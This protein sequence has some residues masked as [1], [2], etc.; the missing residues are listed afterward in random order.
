MPLHKNTM[1]GETFAAA[2]D[3]ISFVPS[4][5]DAQNRTVDVV[6]YGGLTVPRMDQQTWEPY[7]LRLNMTGCRLERLNAGAPV[8][9]CHMSGSDFKS[10]MA[11]QA[12]AKAQRGSVVKAWAEGPKGL[13]TLQF[14]VEGEN[15]DT[16]QLWS[17]IASGRVRN[18]S[19]GSYIYNRQPVKDAQGNGITSPHPDGKLAPVFEATDWEPFEISAVTV[20]ADFTTEFLSA[21]GAEV[22]RAAS[23]QQEKI[24]MPETTTAGTEARTEQVVLDAA[25]AEGA[26]LER[27]RVAEITTLGTSFKLETLGAT[28]VASGATVAEARV[29]FAAAAEIHA[30]GKPMAKYGITQEFVADLV[31]RGMTLEAARAKIQ[32]ELVARAGQAVTGEAH[33]THE[34]IAITRDQQATLAE[35][36]SAALLL[37]HNPQFFGPT[38]GA[39]AP[40]VARQQVELARQY[41]GF[42]L[43]DLARDYLEFSGVK[44]RGMSPL[45]IAGK[46]LA[47]KRPSSNFEMFEGG[48][49]STADFPSILA[50][51]ANK[52]LVMAYQAYPQTFKP[53]A[54]Q[55][56]APDF[57]PINRAFLSDLAAL[58]KLNEKGEYHRAVLTDGN[59][60]YTLATYGEIVALTRR[61]IINDD[62]Q[63]FTRVPAELGVATSRMQSD[64]VW[65]I[66]LANPSAVYMGDKTS[67]ALF[68][69]GHKN[70]QTTASSAF[71]LTSLA[72]GRTL[73]RQQTGAQGTPLNLTP[74]YLVTGTTLE[75]TVEQTIYPMQLAVT[76]VTAGVPQWVRSLVPIVEPR[77]DSLATYGATSWYLFADPADVA[78]LEYAFLEGQEGVFMETR[79]GFEVDG[80]E[81]KAR[82]DFG[83]A[84]IDY[85][86]IQRSNGA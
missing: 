19:F 52:T 77:L 47:S 37:R 59:V 74:R 63:A 18:L 6:W 41:R 5:L 49:A 1:Q 73:F 17:G 10:V 39:D 22:R 11:N 80:M 26:S 33:R 45:E 76:A 43:I 27:Q 25:R 28:L 30:I 44:T 32:D 71:S 24:V 2:S 62:L 29:R 9:D 15:A 8:F 66:I 69:S 78:G 31:D 54:R 50:N 85:R 83:A 60:A 79:Q 16:D 64:I 75:T 70:L 65:G 35:Q 86:G 46:A 14:G 20:P 40:A 81:V 3:E 4:T 7:N 84:A 21:Q 13:A 38:S 67:V 56:T 36:M 23:P 68:A 72:S 55:V 48:A 61:T 34:H 82:A 12:G 53:M 51:V 42:R 58:P 57:K